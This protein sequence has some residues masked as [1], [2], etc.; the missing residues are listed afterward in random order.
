MSQ[1]NPKLR[2]PQLE[3][4]IS[5]LCSSSNNFHTGLTSTNFLPASTIAS[6]T[7]PSITSLD[8]G[9]NNLS[10]TLQPLRH[11]QMNDKGL[12]RKQK[13]RQ[14]P[15]PSS[16]PSVTSLSSIQVDRIAVHC[17]GSPSCSLPGVNQVKS[18]KRI[19]DANSIVIAPEVLERL[20]RWILG[21]AIGESI[22]GWFRSGRSFGCCDCSGV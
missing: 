19:V 10:D 7:L 5:D 22:Y 6:D 16:P 4:D 9:F 8:E 18:G 1:P 15:S 21:F 2:E 14:L 13:S 11:G 17:P 3:A 12:Q 20:R